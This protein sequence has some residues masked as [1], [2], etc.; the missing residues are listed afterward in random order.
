VVA[1][2]AAFNM[3][4]HND[5]G[6]ATVVQFPNGSIRVITEPGIFFRVSAN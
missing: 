3:F 5:V 1:I 6:Y 4:D 2:V